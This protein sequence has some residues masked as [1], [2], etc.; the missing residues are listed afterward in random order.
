[1]DKIIETF[2][3]LPE[4]VYIIVPSSLIAT[5]IFYISKNEEG[6]V[7]FSMGFLLMCTIITKIGNLFL[8]T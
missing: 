8:T 2:E 4:P 1:M 6:G 3:K 7:D 5:G